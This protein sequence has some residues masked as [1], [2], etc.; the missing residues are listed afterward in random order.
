MTYPFKLPQLPY[1]YNALE[2]HMDEQTMKIHHTKHH[3]AY[4][5]KLNAA[6]E[7]HKELHGKSVEELLTNLA[8]VPDAIR[9]AVRNHGGGHLN[10]S[11]FWPLMIMDAPSPEGEVVGAIEEKFGS[12]DK[13]KEQFS[14]AAANHFGSGWAW[15]VLNQGQLEIMTTPNQDNPISQHRIPVL[16][17]DLWEHSYYLKWQNKRTDY[18]A[19][20]WNVV[21]WE[22]INRHFRAAMK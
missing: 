1:D 12:F 2:P 4:V 9:T 13:F 3:Q 7:P 10:H 8:G 18:I 19:T 5:D 6:L 11:F 17:I 15:L 22:E 16:G 14:A 21:N 20:W